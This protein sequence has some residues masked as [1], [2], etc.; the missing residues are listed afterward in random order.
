MFLSNSR[1]IKVAT[2]ECRTQD[3]RT[4]RAVKL[5]ILPRTA[6]AATTVAG[7]DRLDIMAQQAFQDPTLFWHIADANTELQANTLVESTGRTINVPES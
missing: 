3:G 2:I 5:R 6:G 7:H 4:V 1:Y